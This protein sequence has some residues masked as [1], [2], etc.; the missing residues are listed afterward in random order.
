MNKLASM[1]FQLDFS[2]GKYFWLRNSIYI[3]AILVLY[4]AISLLLF[5]KSSKSSDKGTGNHYADLIVSK[6]ASN[7]IILFLNGLFLFSLIYYNGW[8]SFDFLKFPF[9]LRNSYLQ[10]LHI[11]IIYL[12]CSVNYIYLSKKI[13]K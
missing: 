9:S 1:L 6:L 13:K 12:F 5:K 3:I 10:F 4:L 8:M 11:L 2:G 7:I